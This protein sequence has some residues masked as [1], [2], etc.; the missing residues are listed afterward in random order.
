MFA[1]NATTPSS[2]AEPDEPLREPAHRD[3]LQPRA[4]QRQALPD[5]EQPEVAVPQRA[6]RVRER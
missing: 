4:D 5:E 1:Q 3:L 6:K 2:N